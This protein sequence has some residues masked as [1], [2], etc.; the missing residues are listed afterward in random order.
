M[1][2]VIRGPWRHARAPSTS[3]AAKRERLSSVRPAAL[4]FLVDKMSGHHAEG[5]LSRLNHLITA[6]FEAP[7]SEA[8]SSLESQRS[9][10]DR[11]DVGLRRE[12]DMP[13]LLGQSVPNYKAILVR[14]LK[15]PVGHPVPM[16]VD[17]EKI[18][19]SAWQKAFQERLSRIQGKRTHK[20]MAEYFEM[21]EESWKKCVNRGDAFPIRKLPKLALLAGVEVE[22]LITGDRD[23]ELPSQVERYKRRP[24]QIAKRRRAD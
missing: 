24:A 2:N 3:R 19:A 9:M 10:M 1:P 5:M 22:D 23:D 15:T 6:Q 4:A 8:I 18:A 20:K 13:E 14:D 12:S 7:T 17:P 21:D 11:N 16:S